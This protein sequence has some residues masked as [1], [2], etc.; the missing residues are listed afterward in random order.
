[1]NTDIVFNLIVL[2]MQE[3]YSFF[4]LIIFFLL[5]NPRYLKHFTTILHEIFGY[6]TQSDN[7]HPGL[8]LRKK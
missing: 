3:L 7:V 4:F 8:D 1:M 2:E 5:D 6:K